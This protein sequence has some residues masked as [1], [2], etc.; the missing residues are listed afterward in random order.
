MPEC[1]RAVDSINLARNNRDF[2][3]E[4]VASRR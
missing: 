2:T 4:I 1:L 3:A